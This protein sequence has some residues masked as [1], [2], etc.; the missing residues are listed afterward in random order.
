MINRTPVDPVN[1][2]YFQIDGVLQAV[3]INITPKTHLYDT[4]ALDSRWSAS[5]RR[6]MVYVGQ[7]NVGE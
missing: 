1:S 6:I 2:L 5:D 4:F 7:T 3:M